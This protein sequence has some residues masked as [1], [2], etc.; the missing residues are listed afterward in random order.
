MAAV[1]A[2]VLCFAGDFTAGVLAS[3]ATNDQP[4]DTSHKCRAAQQRNGVRAGSYDRF[5]MALPRPGSGVVFVRG[6][7][8]RRRCLCSSYAMMPWYG[9]HNHPHT[10]PPNGNFP[11]PPV[12]HL[13]P[14]ILLLYCEQ[15]CE[16][17]MKT[18]TWADVPTHFRSGKITSIPCNPASC[19]R[20]DRQVAGAVDILL[21]PASRIE[22]RINQGMFRSNGW[23]PPWWCRACVQFGVPSDLRPPCTIFLSFRSC[24]GSQCLNDGMR[25]STDG[26]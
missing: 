24:L 4:A 19:P 15:G 9:P 11:F 14:S 7:A 5:P 26:Y 21:E 10:T 13:G 2:R 16:A 12:S 20:P 17:E 3:T 22:V 23:K 18:R 6:L 8:T 25:S 1:I